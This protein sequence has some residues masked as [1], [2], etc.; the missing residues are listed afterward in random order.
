MGCGPWE[1][2][3]QEGHRQGLAAGPGVSWPGDPG[4]AAPGQCSLLPP[5][6]RKMAFQCR[7]VR[8]RRTSAW[9]WEPFRAA[10]ISRT[11]VWGPLRTASLGTP[12][13]AALLTKQ[14]GETRPS[15]AQQGP[16]SCHGDGDGAGRGP[17]AARGAGGGERPLPHSPP[18]HTFVVRPQ[19]K[20]GVWEA[21]AR[22]QH[23]LL[24]CACVIWPRARGRP[25]R[26]RRLHVSLHERACKHAC[27]Y[28]HPLAC[29]THLLALAWGL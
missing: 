6:Y 17:G 21:K 10:S 13:A 14:V 15:P 2:V 29:R 25:R 1:R 18:L 16:R 20:A 3:G 11:W 19:D 7:S 22:F 9:I 24:P 4:S 26:Q 8:A 12:W 28:A 27:M 23:T 5:T